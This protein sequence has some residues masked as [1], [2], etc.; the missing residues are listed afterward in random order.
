MAYIAGWEAFFK[1]YAIYSRA[2]V[3]W[4]CVLCLLC[5]DPAQH[6]VVAG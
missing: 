2:D 4:V 5:V 3:S 1:I 6:L